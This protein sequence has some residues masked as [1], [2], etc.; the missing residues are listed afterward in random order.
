MGRSFITV[1]R[2][3][4]SASLMLVPGAVLAQTGTIGGTVR[5]AS[6]GVLPGVTV[7]ATSPALIEKVRVA[8]TDSRGIFQIVDLRPGVYTVTFTLPGFNTIKREGVELTA[9]FVAN[10]SIELSV[11]AVEETITVSTQS[12]LV[13]IQSSTQ[14]RTISETLIRDLPTGKAWQNLA[15]L[16]PGALVT[17]AAG[18]ITGQDV[19]GSSG[20]KQAIM[21]FHGSRSAEMPN[22][23]DGMRHGSPA[24][25]GGGVANV[26]AANPAMVAEI[27][28]DTSGAGADAE[29]S[30]LRANTIPKSGGDQFSGYFYADFDNDSLQANNIDQRLRQL[31]VTE[32]NVTKKVW[33]VNPAFG[34]PLKVGKAWFYSAYRYAGSNEQPAGVYFDKD[35][36]DFVFTPT[37]NGPRPVSRNWMHSAAG[38]LTYQTS[39]QSKLA[40]YGDYEPRC[41]CTFVGTLSSATVWD[42]TGR[43]TIPTNGIYQGTWNWTATDR[44]LLQ[45]GET[46]KAE[47]WIPKFQPGEPEDRISIRDVGSGITYR[48][49]QPTMS[50]KNRSHNG[51]AVITYVT[52]SHTVKVGSDWFSGW[53]IRSLTGPT[54]AVSY[55]FTNSTP[56]SVTLWATPT[57]AKEQLKLNMGTYAQ[58]SW[59]FE[60]LTLNLGVRFDYANAYVPEQHAPA[61]RFVGPRDIARINNLPNYKDVSPRLGGS[62][63]LFGDGKTAIKANVS[64]YMEGMGGLFARDVN[65]MYPTSTDY[66]TTTRAW[67]DA[68]VNFNPDCD[69]FNPAANGECGPNLNANF[70]K[71]FVPIRYDPDVLSGINKRG[72]NWESMLGIQRQLLR[73]V[74]VDMSYHRRWFGN[75]RVTDN[76]LVTQ[77]DYDP[78]CVTAPTDSRLP[79][80]GGYPVCGLYD[81]R[82]DKVGVSD[83][84]VTLAKKFGKQTEVYDGV[85][86]SVNARLPRGIQFQGGGNSG[87]SRTNNCF[88]IDS[89]QQLLYCDV[90]PPFLT[91]VKFLGVAPLP[92]AG[93]EVSATYQSLPGPQ[94]LA[95]W[96]APV[97]SVSGLG[98]PVSGGVRTVTVPLVAPGTLYGDRLHQLDL[99]LSKTI[100]AGNIRMRPQIDAYNLTNSNPV[101]NQNNTYGTSWLR[102]TAVLP[103][104]IFKLGVQAEF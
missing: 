26:W 64:R 79:G 12:P 7:E 43:L 71:P 48:S 91:Q 103:G 1:A 101:L 68:N 74:S 34:G 69:L 39:K 21:S 5:D 42:A 98:R 75:F 104:R 51:K 44:L 80:G 28:I 4:F 18:A 53:V 63:D 40:V 2:I 72:W 86:Y 35:P 36:N 92:W 99:R 10:L 90:R 37:L 66:L 46:Y 77:A 93:F 30:G 76:L 38:R 70:G 22:I 24:N 19:G 89:P 29:V 61:I 87:R 50:S 56:T 32:P 82:P 55:T 16:I 20:Q 45:I 62:Y 11:G 25:T 31:G 8:Q 47:E 73:G 81:I 67:T 65:P 49:P 97:T 60:R 17:S 83:N 13:D 52:G 94:I 84:V 6:G 88:A 95:N 9:G 54:P 41:W 27:S 14:H 33:D 96:A 15:A 57:Y 59:V 85:D 3:V 23:F 102:P 78:F 58:D 100:R